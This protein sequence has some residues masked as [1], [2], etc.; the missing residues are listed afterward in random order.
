MQF[1]DE[2]NSG[3][4]CRTY[5]ASLIVYNGVG[6]GGSLNLPERRLVRLMLGVYQSAVRRP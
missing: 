1:A 6:W 3:S 4:S 5:I 2:H